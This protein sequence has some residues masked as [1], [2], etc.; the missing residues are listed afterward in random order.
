[1]PQQTDQDDAAVLRQSN[2]TFQVI[3]TDHFRS[4]IDDPAL[5]TRI[6]A[7]HALG[8]VWAMGAQPQVGLASI[9]V[10]QMSAD[11]QARH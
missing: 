11:L 5:M 4:L 1:M 6:A 3:S 2:G 9:V 10:P 8:D 7:V